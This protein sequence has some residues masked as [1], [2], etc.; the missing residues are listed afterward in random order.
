[1]QSSGGQAAWPGLSSAAGG[2]QTAEP[3]SHV[4]NDIVEQ[5]F[6]LNC[7]LARWSK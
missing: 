2:I 6:G 5:H 3:V 1:M 4:K 7:P